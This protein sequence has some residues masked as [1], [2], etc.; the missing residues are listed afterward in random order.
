M[1]AAFHDRFVELFE[2]NFRRL[3]GFL[4]RLSGEPDQAADLAQEA[5]LRLYRRGSMPENPEA[6]L[7]TVATNLFRNTRSTRAR[8]LRL[9][10]AARSEV[11]LSDPPP[12]PARVLEEESAPGRVRR[13]LDQLD[14]RDRRLLLLRSEGYSYR[15][16]AIALELTESSVGTL[17]A[18]AKHAFR[19]AYG[20]VPEGSDAL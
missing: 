12:S 16:I 4:D 13:A 11:A 5:F 20:C 14:E 6:W 2:A 3:F 1:N 7:V 8:R 19:D 15:E 9:L 17:L 18:R 10:P